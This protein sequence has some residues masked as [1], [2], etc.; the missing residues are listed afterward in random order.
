[1]TTQRYL[2]D[3]KLTP[4][5]VWKQVKRSVITSPDGYLLFDD[6]V[7]DKN[8]SREIEVCASAV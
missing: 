1:M 8:Y 6:T 4:R 7:A 5:L 2:R 3:D